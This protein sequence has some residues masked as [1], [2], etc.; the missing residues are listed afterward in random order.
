MARAGE[1]ESE[2]DREGHDDPGVTIE[3][4]AEPRSEPSRSRSRSGA[5]STSGSASAR[6][7]LRRRAGR[8]FSPRSLVVA[9]AL[10]T[11]GFLAASLLLPFGSLAGLAGVAAGAFVHGLWAD[12][13]RYAETAVAGAAVAGVGVLLDYLV[14]S[15]LAGAGAPVA[16]F[17]VGAGAAVAAAG[18]YFG[19]DLRAGLTRSVE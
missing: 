15:V 18:H 2:R 11:V 10:A 14:L 5:T 16:V 1:R 3:A 17:G 12:A 6:S 9:L 8:L 7:R 19:R 4:D 13:R